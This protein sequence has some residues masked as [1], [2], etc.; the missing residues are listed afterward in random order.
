MIPQYST[1][2]ICIS[3]T[4]TESNM[5]LMGGGGYTY[6]GS[7]LVELTRL[8]VT[9]Q[10]ILFLFHFLEQMKI[11]QQDVWK[12]ITY[13]H[14]QFVPAYTVKLCM[15]AIIEGSTSFILTLIA[16]CIANVR[17]SY[18]VV[19]RIIVRCDMCYVF[20][21]RG[22]DHSRSPPPPIP[23]QCIEHPKSWKL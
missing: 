4:G 1:R 12:Y 15:S 8:D 13:I 9:Q 23:H 18:F 22:Q 14:T 11:V 20:Q 7:C 3:Y 2:Y 10:N 5:C 17:F 6:T 21:G 16:I 19:N